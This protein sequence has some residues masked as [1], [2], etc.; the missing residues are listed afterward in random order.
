M[1]TYSTQLSSSGGFHPV[2]SLTSSSAPLASQCALWAHLTFS[3]SFILDRF[4]LL[5]LHSE[6]RLGSPSVLNPSQ[7][8][9]VVGDTDLEAPVSRAGGAEMLL[10]LRSEQER[11]RYTEVAVPLHVRYQVPVAQRWDSIG[12]ERLD[13]LPVELEWATIFWACAVNENDTREATICPSSN[14]P[15]VLNLTFPATTTRLDFLSPSYYPP[16]VVLTECPPLPLRRELILI[17]TGVL[18]DLSTVETINFLTVWIGAIWIAWKAVGARRRWKFE[19][20]KADS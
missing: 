20:A 14:L 17:P 19:D 8:L 5:Q 13:R 6:G 3:P 2:L 16:P 1:D 15:S 10:R 11:D 12:V 18:A 9:Q 4:Q 7:T